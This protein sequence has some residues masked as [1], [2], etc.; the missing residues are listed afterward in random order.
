MKSVLH[1]LALPA[2]LLLASMPRLAHAG[3]LKVR[4]VGGE[5]QTVLMCP[6]CSAPI[7]C[8]KAGD[9]PVAFSADL[10]EPAPLQR[11]RLLVRIT[12][13]ATGAP[14]NVARVAVALSMSKQGHWHEITPPLTLERQASGAYATTTTRLMTGA[15]QVEVR[16]TTVKGDTVQQK[17]AFEL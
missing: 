17:Y 16:L 10:L 9:Y 12:N 8:A 6:D 3:P 5:A 4:P 11:V 13:P 14:V 7:A 15:W 2:A 1:Q